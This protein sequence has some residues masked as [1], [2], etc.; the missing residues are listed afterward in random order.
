MYD[1]P[2]ANTTALLLKMLMLLARSRRRGGCSCRRVGLPTPIFCPYPATRPHH[3]T[4]K[5]SPICTTGNMERVSRERRESL[6]K[7]QCAESQQD[8]EKMKKGKSADGPDPAM[9]TVLY[10]GGSPI[11]RDLHPCCCRATRRRAT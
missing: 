3:S 1:R 10:D 8:E 7:C 11:S 4:D 6:P 5:L 9:Y 2:T